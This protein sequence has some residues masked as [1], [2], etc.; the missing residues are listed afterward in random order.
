MPDGQQSKYYIRFF[1]PH[2]L[3]S[4]IYYCSKGIAVRS[5][6]TETGSYLIR[7]L[8]KRTKPNQK[9]PKYLGR[10]CSLK[11]SDARA[12]VETLKVFEK[13]VVEADRIRIQ[14]AKER[15]AERTRIEAAEA[16]PPFEN[17]TP[18]AVD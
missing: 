5:Y 18:P 4:L 6:K 2:K 14:I 1:T 15:Q 13:T 7:M 9:F 12:F 10:S 8:M 3:T 11:I 17:V 16:S